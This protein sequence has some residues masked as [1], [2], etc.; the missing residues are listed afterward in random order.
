MTASAQLTA[1]V[2]TSLAAFFG[3]IVVISTLR[4]RSSDDPL[5][6]RFLF[7]MRL[8]AVLLIG[9]VL[10]WTTDYAIA[11]FVTLAAAALIPLAALLLSEGLLRRHAP[12]GFKLWAA[13]GGAAFAILAFLPDAL[14]E[15]GRTVAML[16]FQLLS[17][18]GLGWL[19]LTRDRDSLSTA[20]NRTVDR[21]ALALVL[22]IPFMITDY[23][24]VLPGL[25]VRLGGIAILFL[26]WLAIGLG[27][28]SLS[29]RDA[30][31]GF[32]VIALAAVFAGAALG[33]TFGTDWPGMVQAAAIVLSASLLAVCYND[34]VS[35]LAEERRETLIRHIAEGDLD[36]S[37]AFLRGLQDHVLVEGA[38]ILTERDLEDFDVG[39]L[40]GV[41][42]RSP[43]VSRAGLRLLAQSGEDAREQLAWLFE[44]FEATHVMLCSQAP[45]TL[46]ALN[47][48]ALTSSPGAETELRAV[49][50]V[51]LLISRREKAA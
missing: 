13:G 8:L 31:A 30:I 43:V 26:C 21:I 20:E 7:G 35:L 2:I 5:L 15:P 49:Q 29:H 46:V 14:V 25:P 33:A 3:L 12:P 32:A 48:P 37:A 17:F 47:M 28:P 36:G 42:G 4:R 39:V 27:R 22:I 19:V 16:I 23:R 44:R 6:R 45:L 51:A 11:G 1:D 38:L 40:S 10:H 18:A 50:R 9:R 24:F 41:F 34:S